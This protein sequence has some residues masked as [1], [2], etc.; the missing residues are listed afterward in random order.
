[1]IF[2]LGKVEKWGDGVLVLD[3]EY[4]QARNMPT[5]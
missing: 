4:I 1:M 2:K 5:M 3:T